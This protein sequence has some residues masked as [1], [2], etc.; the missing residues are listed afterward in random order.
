MLLYIHVP[1]CRSKCRYCA[2]ASEVMTMDAVEAWQRAVLAEAAHWG[3]LLGRPALET[4]Y[5]GG[6]TP[7]LLPGWAFE[8]LL[9]GIR[10]AFVVPKD[11]EFTLEANPDSASDKDLLKL[12]RA[13]G[14]N[15][16]S[17]GVQSLAERD[18]E[19]LGRPHGAA[20][21]LTAVERVRASGFANLSIDLI[22]GLPGTRL[23]SWMDNL[24][25]A[26]RLGPEHISCYGLTLEPGTP[27]AQAS[28]AGTLLLPGEDEQAKMYVY[29]GEYLE[30][31]GYLHY[32]IS[33]FARMGYASVHNQ[34][35][36]EGKEYLG[37]GPSAVS[38]I[39]GRRWE[40]PKTVKDYVALAG[41]KAWGWEA[42]TL[43]PEIR[44]REVLMLALRTSKGMKL[45]EYN[46]LM[47]RN[48]VAEQGKLLAALRQ[49]E[50]IRIKDGS[51]R[52]TRQGM[53][54]SNLI[55]TRLLFPEAE[56]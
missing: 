56:S 4:V 44:A 8:G 5:M 29:G 20:Q 31:Q 10:K 2:F 45:A 55:L 54:V 18:L 37:L 26:V 51:L 1:F 7:S 6:G 53:L 28:E 43:S 13:S 16:L 21:V 9:R 48:L 24:K 34:G 38:T 17:L 3:K 36:W 41:R 35:Y 32:E 33:N 52:L 25:A 14:V 47:G 27:L 50:L 42:E 49:K 15:R 39:G 19:M 11:I 23:K 30:E 22:W 40:N 12:W 46:R